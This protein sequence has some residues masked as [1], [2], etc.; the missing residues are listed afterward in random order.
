MKDDAELLR[1][2]AENR[3]NEAFTELVRRHLDFVYSAALRQ[4]NGDAHL[5]ADV[6]QIVFVDLARKAGSLTGHRALAGWLFIGT[7]YTAAKLIRTEQRRRAREQRAEIMHDNDQMDSPA[8]GWDGISPVL[9][10]ALAQLGTT[11]RE[12]VLLRFFEGRAFADIGARFRLNENA[13][14]MRVE[15]ALDKLRAQLEKRGLTSTSAA[16]AAAL[17]AQGVTAAPSGLAAAV[18]VSAGTGGGSVLAAMGTFMS[19]NKLS[20]GIAAAIVLS[21]GI[22]VMIQADANEQ[23]HAEISALREQSRDTAGLREANAQL[24]RAA[25]EV[26]ELRRDDAEFARLAAEI[27]ALRAS[28]SQMRDSQAAGTSAGSKAAESSS[29]PAYTLPRPTLQV[30]PVIPYQMRRAG[31]EGKVTVQLIVGSDGGVVD[32]H[33]LESELTAA[34]KVIEEDDIAV[35]DTVTTGEIR[36]S[37][38]AAAV[39]AVSAWKFEPGSRNQRA[40]NTRISVPIVFSLGYDDAKAKAQAESESKLTEARW[41]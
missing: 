35:T 11:D 37:M 4:V 27:Q 13:A 24:A 41:F 15:R 25:A 10:E 5:A 20:A 19:M 1:H 3:S 14:R 17:A 12:A 9:D 36:A 23:L 30:H 28:F 16:L 33:A 8:T 31:L 22:G 18:A 29:P 39:A 21:C 2:F 6:A 40:V 32:A 26:D 38:E 7:R 34:N